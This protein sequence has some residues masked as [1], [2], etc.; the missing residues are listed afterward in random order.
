MAPA[1]DP[2]ATAR[3]SQTRPWAD[4]PRGGDLLKLGGGQAGDQP[5]VLLRGALDQ[6][7]D[8][9]GGQ[10]A[11]RVVALR[12][13]QEPEGL[14]LGGQGG[15]GLDADGGEGRR[16]G[17]RGDKRGVV[18]DNVRLWFRVHSASGAMVQR[19]NGTLFYP[20][21]FYNSFR[22]TRHAL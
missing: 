3:S 9:R 22:E 20:N 8:E 13:G 11:E 6:R 14:R 1:S 17:G 10:F 2:D 19:K 16:L 4:V 21:F 7:G 12:R 5:G 18:F 15:Q